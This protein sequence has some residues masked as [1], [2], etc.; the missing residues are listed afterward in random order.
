MLNTPESPPK[1]TGGLSFYFPVLLGLFRASEG[2][3]T[4]KGLF[5]AFSLS[6]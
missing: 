3:K 4:P 1:A 2:S 5:L 6:I